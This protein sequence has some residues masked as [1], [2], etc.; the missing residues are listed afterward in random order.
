MLACVTSLRPRARARYL[1]FCGSSFA[2]GGDL[3]GACANSCYCKEGFFIGT[4]GGGAGSGQT[5]GELLM[6]SKGVAFG[7]RVAFFDF[8]DSS[9][10]L[11][12][13]P[14]LSTIFTPFLSA[15]AYVHSNSWGNT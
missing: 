11:H 9:S 5:C 4:G 1:S 8:G 2:D 3:Q 7:G 12:G 15:G 10:N 13:P 14:S 6:D